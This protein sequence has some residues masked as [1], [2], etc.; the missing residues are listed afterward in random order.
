MNAQPVNFLSLSLT[1]QPVQIANEM[2]ENLSL[3]EDEAAFI[4]KMIQE[5]VASRNS[6][7]PPAVA[8]A[9]A[10]GED[11]AAAEPEAARESN[12]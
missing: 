7:P 10:G 8:E 1:L 9:E 12:T 4:A 5:H 11:A 3:K 2:V 6:N